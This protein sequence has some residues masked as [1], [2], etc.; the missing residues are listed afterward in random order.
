MKDFGKLLKDGWLLILLV[1]LFAAAGYSFY[2]N[3]RNQP[4][5]QSVGVIASFAIA[6]LLALVTWQYA[7]ATQKTL[8]LYREQWEFQQKVG[9]RFGM[10]VRDDKPW[11]RIVN[12]G[13]LGFMVT[14]AVFLHRG[15]P[16]HT[17]NTYT[18]VGPGEKR[19]FF[20]PRRVYEKEPHHCDVDV[21]LHYEHY[22]KSENKI[23]RSFRIELSRGKVTGIKKGFQ[24]GWFVTCPKCENQIAGFMIT[25]GLEN[26]EQAKAR[27]DEMKEQFRVT[28]PNH[29]SPWEA[30]VE[31]IRET[32]ESEKRRG[33]EE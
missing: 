12:P 3:W 18:M 7:R 28:C 27:E 20:I 19:G 10:S 22:G 21:T 31:G 6:G 8:D 2:L 30:T 4:Q 32:N 17:L 1:L 9:I 24:S 16:P 23:S 11:V 15:N 14:K 26:F 13:G 25:T 29:Q 5:L 33:T